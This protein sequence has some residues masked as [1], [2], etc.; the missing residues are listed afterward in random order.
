MGYPDDKWPSEQDLRK[1]DSN[2][3]DENDSQKEAD[4]TF[5][6]IEID[7]SY[8]VSDDKKYVLTLESELMDDE[9][10][11]STNPIRTHMVYYYLGDK[12][13][14]MKTIGEFVDADNARKAFDEI[15]ESDEDMTYYR[16]KDKY[17]IVTG[18]ADQYEGMTVSDVKEQ[19]DF[20]ESLK[21]TDVEEPDID[22]Y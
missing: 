10:T 20:M 9:E 4:D 14:G 6:D 1:G 2:N 11:N 3:I 15:K 16:L 5:N 13:T 12:I 8:F 22:D 17:I 7:D 19:I 21:N 18:T